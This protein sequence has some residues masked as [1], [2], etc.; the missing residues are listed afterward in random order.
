LSSWIEGEVLGSNSPL[1]DYL[2]IDVA[3]RIWREHLSGEKN[4]RLFVWG[5]IA[6]HLSIASFMRRANA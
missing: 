5:L 1:R 4:H 3:F 2:D 6:L